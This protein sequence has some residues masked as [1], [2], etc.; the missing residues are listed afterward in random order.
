MRKISL[1]DRERL[2]AA[3]AE[4]GWARSL[5]ETADLDD[6]LATAKAGCWMRLEGEGRGLDASDGGGGAL[7]AAL[8]VASARLV[9][10]R[11][12]DFGLPPTEAG[13]TFLLDLNDDWPSPRGGLL[14]FQD[15]DQVAGFRPQAGAVTLFDGARTPL[16]TLVAPGAPDRYAIIGR[17]A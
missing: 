14:L 11:A 15:G 13:T 1:V 12:G 2:T 6:L 5:I 4:R 10:H 3:L 9:R 17:L 7:A 8:G 16:L